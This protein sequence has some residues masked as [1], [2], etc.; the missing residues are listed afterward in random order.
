MVRKLGKPTDQRM[1]LLRNQVSDLLW[2]GRIETTVDR[3]KEVRRLAEKMVTLGIKTYDDVVTTTKKKVNL[4]GEKIDVEFKNDGVRKLAARRK[5]MSFL[6][7]IQEQKGE[8]ESKTAY[9]DRTRDIK[10]PLVEKVF[11]EY[12]PKYAARIEE[13]KQGGGYTRII[14][15]GNRRGD[16][17][18]MA[19]IEMI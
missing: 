10:H 14:K 9:R 12:A 16:N 11:N 6:R 13:T 17:A 18:Q 5:L 3:A 19:I 1:A 8:K 7:D 2:Y 15:T 4:K